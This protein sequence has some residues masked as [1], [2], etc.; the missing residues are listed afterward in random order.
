MKPRIRYPPE[1]G[2]LQ[3]LL[4]EMHS[5][6]PSLNGHFPVIINKYRGTVLSA[7][8]NCLLY[9]VKEPRI[10]PI[11]YPELRCPHSGFKPPSEPG[12]VR[13]YRVKSE[14]LRAPGK[15]WIFSYCRTF[16]ADEG[17]MPESLGE[18]SVLHRARAVRN[19]FCAGKP[20]GNICLSQGHSVI[21]I[22][23]VSNGRGYGG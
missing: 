6:G 17:Q 4:S 12:K 23:I 9:F 20:S 2:C 21:K 1:V 7:Q 11:L 14:L 10:A 15:L 16:R 3:I 22:I 5:V 13:H 18:S 19:P 8:S